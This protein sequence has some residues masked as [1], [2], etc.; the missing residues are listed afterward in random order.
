MKQTPPRLST[1]YLYITNRCNLNCGHCWINPSYTNQEKEKGME[2]KLLIDIL[3]QS[4]ELGMGS[5]KIT[6]GEPLLYD[7]FMGLLE[8]FKKKKQ[9]LFLHMETNGTMIDKRMA[10]ALKEGGMKFVSVSIDGDNPDTH[11]KMR[12]VKGSFRK[13]W[14]AAKEM[15][16]QGIAVQII[17]A[18]YRGNLVQ[19]ENIARKAEAL[20]AESIKANIINDMGRGAGMAGN[21]KLLSI[22]EML[23]LNRKIEGEYRERLKIKVLSTMPV[24]FCSL[25]RMLKERANFCKIK[26]L[27]GI[28]AAGKISICGIGEEMEELIL[29]DARKQSIKEVWRESPILWN[30]RNGL[31][32]KLDG[33]CRIC[34]FKNYC[35]GHCAAQNYYK[36]GSLT[37]SF[38]V[39]QKAYEQGLFPASRLLEHK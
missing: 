10:R 8:Y 39:C 1:I 31:P 26:G 24:A 15:I 6:G 33:V 37:S 2:L 13:A 32:S 38:W 21:D 23:E 14:Q 28:L 9:N 19:F 11:D 22:E 25:K 7:S 34:V 12:G 17:T 3:E 4:F 18:V 20:K 5:L 16:A 36:T 27:L 29:G 30:I 35:L